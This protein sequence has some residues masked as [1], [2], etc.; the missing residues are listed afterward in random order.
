MIQNKPNK[1]Q[2]SPRNESVRIQI[3]DSESQSGGVSADE[4]LSDTIETFT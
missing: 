3:N 2:P 4:S 1:P